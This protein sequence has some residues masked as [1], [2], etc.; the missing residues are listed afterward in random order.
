M[1]YDIDKQGE[2]AELFKAIR[3]IL[4]SYPHIK[5]LKNAHQTSYSDE[6]GVIAMIR[7]KDD[8]YVV[9]LGKGAKLQ[10]LY[11]MLE[12]SGKIVRHLYYKNIED[13]DEALLRELL[14]ESFILSMEAYELK[15]IKMQYKRKIDSES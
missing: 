3:H 10:E 14:E 8:K 11:P 5:E 6:Y 4:L 2:F 1:Q 15:S 7:P 13:L 12:G 9:A